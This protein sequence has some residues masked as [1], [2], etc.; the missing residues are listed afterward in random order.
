[1]EWSLKQWEG[2]VQKRFNSAGLGC[3]NCV[4]PETSA[5]ALDLVYSQVEMTESLHYP[6]WGVSVYLG[7]WAK[8]DILC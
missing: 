5:L 8:A 4:F 6:A 7:P 2:A 1:M 3:S